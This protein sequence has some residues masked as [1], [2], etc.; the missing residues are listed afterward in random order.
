MPSTE[1]KRI[2]IVSMSYYKKY[3]SEV[4][5]NKQ[6]T[7]QIDYNSPRLVTRE[8]TEVRGLRVGKLDIGDKA[9]EAFED[10]LCDPNEGL[11]SRK[12]LFKGVG[13]DRYI[14][15]VDEEAVV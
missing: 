1:S 8:D 9:F 12:S 15:E 7:D 13:V 4:L 6:G 3:V 5:I 2:L 10:S 14:V 11:V